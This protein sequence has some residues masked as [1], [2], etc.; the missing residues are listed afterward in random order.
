VL[1]L[2]RLAVW[3][4]ETTLQALLLSLFLIAMHWDPQAFGKD[5]LFFLSG[6][7][8]LFFTT[9]YLLTTAIVRATWRNRR[10][11]LH[12]IIVAVLFSIHF[13][14]MNVAARGAFEPP[15]RFRFRVAGACIAFACT[16]I[17]GHLLRKWGQASGSRS[18]N[19]R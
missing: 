17:G 14:I 6:I 8:L 19:F 18:R 2:K 7:A 5:L 9:G 1:I 4:L 13:E 3:L 10:F 16:S 11:W 15:E 12:P